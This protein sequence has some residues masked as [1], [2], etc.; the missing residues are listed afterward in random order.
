MK[1]GIKKGG[2]NIKTHVLAFFVSIFVI[3][4]VVAPL[5]MVRAQNA[6]NDKVDISSEGFKVMFCDGPE[7]LRH[8]KPDGVYDATYVNKDFIPC[9]FEG[10]MKQVQRLI[11]IMIVL[12]VVAALGGFSYAG[13]LYITGV[14]DKITRAYEIF[15]KV[16]IGFILMLSA[17]AIVYQILSW[18][19]DENKFKGLLN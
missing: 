5:S 19:T 2:M 14:P 18:L 8:V 11:N 6:A 3:T 17:W 12:G 15:K 9:N 4:A 13:Y 16:G 1:K 7:Q 10:F